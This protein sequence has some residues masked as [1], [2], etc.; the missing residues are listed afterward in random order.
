MTDGLRCAWAR[1]RTAARKC[2]VAA[3][4]PRLEKQMS[5][6]TAVGKCDSLAALARCLAAGTGVHGAALIS[7]PQGHS[8]AWEPPTSSADLG[9]IFVIP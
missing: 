7:S 3:C 5:G 9:V 6:S 8:W 2:G 1:Y 4:R